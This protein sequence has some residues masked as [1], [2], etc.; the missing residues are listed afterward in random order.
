MTLAL[1]MTRDK[2]AV[3]SITVLQADGTAQN[4]GGTTLWFHGIVGGVSIDKSSPSGGISI[5]SASAGTATLTIDPVDTGGI[6]ASG[7]YQGSCELTMVV[8]SAAYELASGVITV[9]PNTA[10]P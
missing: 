6:P 5:I 8:G 7:T 10:I 3:W 1:S 2:T 9:S 4:I